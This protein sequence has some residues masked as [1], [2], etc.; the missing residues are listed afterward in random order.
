MAAAQRHLSCFTSKFLHPAT[1]K[2]PITLHTFLQQQQQHAARHTLAAQHHRATQRALSV[3]RAS[4]TRQQMG[5]EPSIGEVDW[6]PDI[7]N[8]I[9]LVGKLGRDLEVRYLANGNMVGTVGLAVRRT[10][11]K[12][13]WYDDVY[14]IGIHRPIWCA[15][16]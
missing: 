15:T 3:T 2:L 7:V 12:T 1:S 5:A 8:S 14:V 6:A 11:D 4:Y 10:Q 16:P 9:N 13:D